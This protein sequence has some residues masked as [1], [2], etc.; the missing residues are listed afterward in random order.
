[1]KMN[2]AVFLDLNGT[3]V[4]PVKQE[5][6]AELKLIPGA[7][8]AVAVLLEANFICPVVT[9]Q[10]GIGKGRFTDKEFRDWFSDVFRKLKLD[11]KGPYICPHRFAEPCECKKPNLFL[12]EQAAADHA[13]DLSR[14]YVI[15]DTAWD[16]IAGKKMGG[17]GCLVRTGWGENETEY[18]HAKP[19]VA[20]SGKSL[21]DVVGWILKNEK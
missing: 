5:S 14:S 12:Y 10:S 13:I 9:I 19:F 6:L 4:L 18:Q 16:V 21:N 7:D 2:K 1:M 20:Y 3:L 11:I 8:R 15:G 17:Q